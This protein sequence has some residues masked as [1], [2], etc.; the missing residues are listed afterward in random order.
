MTFSTSTF[1]KFQLFTFK[2]YLMNNF[3]YLLCALVLIPTLY[4]CDKDNDDSGVS[5]DKS[6]TS[7]IIGKTSKV[8]INGTEASY[9]AVSSDTKTATVQL[10]GKEMTVTGVKEGSA[11]IT[12]TAKSGK[13]GKVAVSVI[14]D[15]YATAKADTKT[16]LVWNTTSKIEGTDKGTYKLSQ[17]TTGAVEFRWTSEDTKSTIVLTFANAVGAITEGVKTTPKLLIDGKEVAVASL[18]VI[19]AKVVTTGDKETIWIAFTAGGKTGIC[20]GKLI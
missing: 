8:T 4:S 5:F 13:T 16:R 6:K 15:P 17:G 11:V 10:S 19:Q 2:H 18:E 9:T 20:V 7:I 3:K 14:K 12:V 1:L